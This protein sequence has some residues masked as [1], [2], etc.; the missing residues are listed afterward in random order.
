ML[1]ILDFWAEW[2]GPCR[3]MNPII[4][5]IEKEL[6]GKIEVERINV[7]ENQDTASKHNVLSIPTYIFLVDGKEVDRVI[8]FTQK[9]SFLEKVKKQLT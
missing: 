3:M 6:A 2:C 5:E 8:G 1:K 4:D 7:D 9:S